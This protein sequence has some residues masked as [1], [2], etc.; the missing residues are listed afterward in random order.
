MSDARRRFKSEF[1]H[2]FP[3]GDVHGNLIHDVA[4]GIDDGDGPLTFTVGK[5]LHGL[6]DDV[7]VCIEAQPVVAVVVVLSFILL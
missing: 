4:R 7:I 3:I 2:A 5:D 6:D 1:H